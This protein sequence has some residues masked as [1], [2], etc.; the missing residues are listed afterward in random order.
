MASRTRS[1]SRE[2]IISMAVAAELHRLP[3]DQRRSMQSLRQTVSAAGQL[4]Q[5][6]C[7]IRVLRNTADAA[8]GL[9]F[10]E[11][12]RTPLCCKESSRRSETRFRSWTRP[13]LWSRKQPCRRRTIW[14]MTWWRIPTGRLTQC[15]KLTIDFRWNSF[16]LEF[17]PSSGL[18]STAWWPGLC[19][20]WNSHKGTCRIF[21]T[22]W[23][24]FSYFFSIL[25]VQTFQDISGPQQPPFT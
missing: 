14:S 16:Y 25:W 19:E 9:D 21:T 20:Q 1:R 3:Q 6:G 22:T 10:A 2:K 23:F 15:Q 24:H 18:F 7:M 11:S 13:P 8:M 4:A 12:P 5:V 17:F